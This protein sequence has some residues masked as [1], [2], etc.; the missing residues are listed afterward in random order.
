MRRQL[1]SKLTLDNHLQIGC[2]AGLLGIGCLL[3]GSNHVT[4]QDFN[5]EVLKW[6]T[7]PNIVINLRS[8][9]ISTS[10]TS[11]SVTSTSVIS[12][13]VI[14]ADNYD[15]LITNANEDR[16][17]YERSEVEKKSDEAKDDSPAEE[18]SATSSSDN[19]LTCR[20]S[21]RPRVESDQLKV[22]V[23]DTTAKDTI[24]TTAVDTI[25]TTV[26]DTLRS[27]ASLYYGDWS[28]TPLPSNHFDVILTSE[29]IYNEGN[30]R[31]LGTLF[32][33]CVKR[34]GKIIVGAKT[35]YFGVG[36]G[37]RSFQEFVSSQTSLEKSKIL[38]VINSPVQREI[39]MFTN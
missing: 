23:I 36:G 27:K 28:E 3:L 5:L 15:A 29:T 8:S 19:I 31:K 24:P 1:V 21:K 35:H 2:G 10:V 30:Y 9:V 20:A 37:T 13:S 32:E 17:E 4:F 26:V 6:F 22:A 38:K 7:L 16:L 34:G 39:I 33:K 18:S 12:T 25:P 14:S 11:T